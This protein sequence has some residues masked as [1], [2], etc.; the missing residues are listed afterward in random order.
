MAGVPYAT[1]AGF[2]D[3]SLEWPIAV[4]SLG[5]DMKCLLL[6]PECLVVLR[7]A[8]QDSAANGKVV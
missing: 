8:Q 3:Q 6:Q 5:R 4:N 7:V 1:G 2:L